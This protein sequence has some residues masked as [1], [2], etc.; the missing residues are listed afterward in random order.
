MRTQFA[1]LMRTWRRCQGRL[2]LLPPVPGTGPRR[3]LHQASASP[4]LGTGV[5]LAKRVPDDS[6]LDKFPPSHPFSFM[7]AGSAQMASL[8]SELA[9]NPSV[10]NT[11]DDADD[12]LVV[13]LS[14]HPKTMFHQMELVDEFDRVSLRSERAETGCELYFESLD[15]GRKVLYEMDFVPNKIDPIVHRLPT[16]PPS[17]YAFVVQIEAKEY[18]RTIAALHDASDRVT[19]T[20]NKNSITF[21]SEGP[22]GTLQV[23][24]SQKYNTPGKLVPRFKILHFTSPGIKQTFNTRYLLAFAHAVHLGTSVILSFPPNPSG[25]VLSTMSHLSVGSRSTSPHGSRPESPQPGHSA[26]TSPLRPPHSHMRISHP[27]EVVNVQDPLGLGAENPHNDVFKLASA[28]LA[29]AAAT[30]GTAGKVAKD[31]RDSILESKKVV[32]FLEYFLA[33]ESQV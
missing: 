20:G 27:I 12:G 32:G 29:T 8:F 2:C 30:H 21:Q 19:I 1:L 10:V 7:P 16:P 11:N 14:V 17:G 15:L 25:A 28:A 22:N 13:I 4:K 9:C 31:E 24:L 26:S 6:H 23:G 3:Q 5:A 33:P 18:I